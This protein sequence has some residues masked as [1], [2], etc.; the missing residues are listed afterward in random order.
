MAASRIAF[1]RGTVL[2]LTAA[3]AALVLIVA[4]SV[5]LTLRTEENFEETQKARAVRTAAVDLL[6]LMQD[7][8]IGERGY[9][10]SRDEAYL[11]PYASAQAHFQ[12]RLAALIAAVAKAPELTG[13]INGFADLLRARMADAK[14][15]IDLTRR[16]QYEAAEANF[17]SDRGKALMD[18]ARADFDR[19]VSRS[20][21]DLQASIAVERANVRLLT[22]VTILSA[23]AILAMAGVAVVTIMRHTGQLMDARSELEAL[24]RDLEERVRIR[25]DALAKANAEIQRFAYVVTH[26]LRSPLVNIMGFTSELEASLK[27]IEALV[28]AERSPNEAVRA[29]GEQA[30]Q[31]IAPEAIGF[32]RTSTD[33]MDRLVK[34]ILKIS[35]EG[36]RAL[37]PETIDLEAILVSAAG[38]ARRQA[39]LDGG[40]VDVACLVGQIVTD[41]LSLE[42]IIANLVDNALKYRALDRPPRLEIRAR[43]LPSRHV[44][45]VVK[46]NGRGIAEDDCERIF[47]LF[48]RS[49][50]QN[51]PGEGIGLAHVRTMVRNLGGE[52]GVQSQLGGGST[53][54]VMLPPE[55]RSDGGTTHDA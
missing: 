5:R 50:P 17:D 45:I 26:D 36:A 41:R 51:V 37:R 33:K 3:V 34:A 48:R 29:E 39:A 35:R 30:L 40:S 1:L 7:A 4:V 52:I 44:A 19:I 21:D 2:L 42:Q 53:F 22:R 43:R 9:L 14:T 12:E 24:N 31:V 27:P 28:R 15:T 11:T 16:G 13:S 32:I 18:R 49:G 38:A 46:D 20:E 25:T 47:D 55:L 8:E 6:S 54:T 10:L 23:A